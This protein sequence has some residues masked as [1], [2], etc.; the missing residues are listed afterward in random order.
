MVFLLV[1]DDDGDGDVFDELLLSL[2][3]LDSTILIV[4]GGVF[5]FFTVRIDFNLALEVH[6]FS[7]KKRLKYL[8]A[9]V[10]DFLK[11]SDLEW[12]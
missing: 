12:K 1:L 11:S 5:S 6:P 2:V 7:R 4:V 10:T 3:D 9:S 8:P